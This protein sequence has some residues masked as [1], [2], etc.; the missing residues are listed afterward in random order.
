MEADGKLGTKTIAKLNQ[1]M[2]DSV[3]QLRLS[4][5]RWRWLPHNFAEPPI[6]VNI[7]EFKLR[8][9]DAPGKLALIMPVVVGK[10]MRTQT[11]V[12]DEDMSP[13]PYQTRVNT[14]DSAISQNEVVACLPPNEKGETIHHRTVAIP[15]RR[16]NGEKWRAAGGAVGHYHA[17]GFWL[18]L[19][20]LGFSTTDISAI[21]TNVTNQF[22]GAHYTLP[23]EVGATTWQS[24]SVFMNPPSINWTDLQAE[25][26]GGVTQQVCHH[27]PGTRG[28]SCMNEENAFEF[29]S[30]G[31]P[32]AGYRSAPGG[33]CLM[34]VC[35]TAVTCA[36]AVRISTFG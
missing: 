3:E 16:S 7:P 5:E 30:N 31:Q 17:R 14:R 20:Q 32:G 1:P 19:K 23:S 25:A 2:S 36:F 26:S 13:A 6:V 4:L 33:S 29:T 28:P 10:A 24:Y 18:K 12:L 22:A 9:F 15:A 8:A 11:P 35:E 21:I 34:I 27:T